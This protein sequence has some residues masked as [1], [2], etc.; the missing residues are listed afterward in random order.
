MNPFTCIFIFCSMTDRP[1]KPE[2]YILD[3][4]YLRESSQTSFCSLYILL[5]KPQ[6][7]YKIVMKFKAKNDALH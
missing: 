4:H 2:I 1:T 6:I 5:K 3:V 7:E